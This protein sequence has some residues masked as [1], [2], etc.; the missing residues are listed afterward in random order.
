MFFES[1][2]FE[3]LLIFALILVNGFFSA[4]EIAVV[5]SRRARIHKWV[6]EGRKG[7]ELVE[8]WKRNPDPF[9]ATVQIG[10]TLVGSL[11]SALGGAA[12]IEFIKPGLKASPWF[13]P[14]AEPLSIL[15]VVL[16]IT[17]FSLVLGELAPKSLAMRF[18]EKLACW[19]ARP[20]HW[21]SLAFATSVSLLTFPVRLMN[22]LT[23]AKEGARKES[24]ITEEEV[25][26]MIKEGGAQGIFDPTEQ[27][28]IPRVFEFAEKH[29]KDVMIPRS[30]IVAIEV[31]TP[32]DELL[33]IVSEQR[34]S[35][36]P[37]YEKDLDR[38]VGVIHLKDVT[39]LV[40]SNKDIRLREIVRQPIYVREHQLLK[41]VM[42]Y[43]QRRYL[44]MAIV[45]DAQGR[46][47]GLF[48]LEDLVEE[49]VGDIWDEQDILRYRRR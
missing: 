46:T 40:I 2:W 25:K 49:I 35:R 15:M 39:R 45:R 10:V 30:D 36:Y 7:A 38:I 28:M 1:F 13:F 33:N 27:Q 31:S 32:R 14:W 11:A 43:F 23:G 42:G 20:I 4:S 22:S 18:P 21:M 29:V 19:V 26:F 34:Y 41:E 16:P 24:F 17:Y 8:K 9:L 44:H 12:A 47:L 6:K 37:V 5:A 48:T 3:V